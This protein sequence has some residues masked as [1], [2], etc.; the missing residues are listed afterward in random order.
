[1]RFLETSVD[2]LEWASPD[3]EDGIS[4]SYLISTG[5]WTNLKYIYALPGNLLYLCLA[6]KLSYCLTTIAYY[7]CSFGVYIRILVS[8]QKIHVFTQIKVVSWLLL[9]THVGLYPSSCCI[10]R[11]S[12][13][14]ILSVESNFVFVSSKPA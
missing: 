3:D 12:R 8:F 13:L 4:P 6:I 5:V 10:V 9:L 11:V 14:C 2:N 1:M 7:R